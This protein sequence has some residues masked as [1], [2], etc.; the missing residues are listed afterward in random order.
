MD[1]LLEETFIFPA[2]FAQ[3]R[4]W[5]FHQFKPESPF[6]NV[7]IAIRL[8]GTLNLAALENSLKAIIGRHESLRTTFSMTE[9]EPI[10]IITS[11]LSLNIPIIDLQA[12]SDR[13]R[14]AEVLRLANEE[15]RG[16]FDLTTGPLMRVTLLKL[17]TQTHALLLTMHH[18]ISDGWSMNILVRE[19]TALYSAS[20][21]GEES[22]LP[23]LPIQYADYTMWQRQQLQGEK[24]QEQLSYWKHQLADAPPVLALPIDHPRP[25][26]Q[27]FRGASHTFRLPQ[28]L[29]ASLHALSQREGVTLFMTLLAAF[30]V[31]LAR[32]SGQQD[33]LVGSPSA[34]RRRPEIEGLIGF[35]V[36]TLVFR[37]DL[38]GNPGFRDLLQRVKEVALEAYMHQDIPFEKLIEEL[39]PERELSL[40]PL[41]QVMFTLQNAQQERLALAS[42]QLD[43]IPTESQTAKV[44]LEL[45]LWEFSGELVGDVR[46]NTDVF[47]AA[48]IA[49]MFEHFRI[50]L[51]GIVADAEQRI[52]ELPLLT[53]T[54]RQ[55]LLYEWNDTL[56]AYPRDSCIHHLF[57]AQARCTPD[58]IAIVFEDQQ[59]TYQELDQ[60]AN[61]LAHYLQLFGVGPEVLVGLCLDRSITM[62]IGLL[63]ILKAG[64]AY[65]PLDSAYPKERLAFILHDA[66]MLVLLTQQSL[67]E[68]LSEVKDTQVLCVDTAWEQITQQSRAY[69]ASAVGPRNLAYV[70]YTSGSTGTP[71]GVQIEHRGLCNISLAQ[72]QAFRVAARDRFLQFASLSFDVS[73]WEIV[74]TFTNGG[75]LILAPSASLLP[76]PQLL[77]LLRHQAITIVTLSPSVLTAMPVI[78]LPDLRTLIAAG[79]VCKADLVTRWGSEHRF[80]NAYGPTEITICA[81]VAH[82]SPGQQPVIGR[83]V[84]NAQMYVLDAFLQPVPIGVYGELYLGGTGSA[85]GYL[86]RAD[87][88]AERFLPHPFSSE[89]G[90]RLY[91][92]GDLAR[93][94]P[95]GNLEFLER[96]DHQVK[97]RGFRIELGEIEMVLA[98]HPDVREAVVIAREDKAEGRI[99][100][101]YVTAKANAH[102]TPAILRQVLEERLPDYM[103]PAFFVTL[104]TMPLNSSGKL[105]RRA[106]PAPELQHTALTSAFVPPRSV[107]E[108]ILSEIWSELLGI[109]PVG[110]RDDFFHLGGHSL[111]TLRLVTHIEARFGQR[112]PLSAI[113]QGRTIESLAQLLD[114]PDKSS[115]WSPLVTLQAGASRPPFFCV[116]PVEGSVT[117]YI[118][119][120][121]ALGPEQPFYALQA[122][123]L[124]GIQPVCTTIEEM[125]A[126]YIKAIQTVQAQGPYFL[127]GWSL[128]GTVAFEMARQLQHMGQQ[129]ALLALL[130]SWAPVSQ[131]KTENPDQFLLNFARNIGQGRGEVMSD[132]EESTFQLRGQDE[133]LRS[134]F[135]W[136]QR[137][138]VLS[139]EIHFSQVRQLFHV[140]RANREA[141]LS[142]QPEIYDG[143]IVLMRT[144]LET[145]SDTEDMTRGW[146]ELVTRGVE[147]HEFPGNHYTIVHNPHVVASLLRVCLER[148]YKECQCQTSHV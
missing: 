98:A 147:V 16:L 117:C 134:V 32:S 2:S 121:S 24:L 36:N 123:G 142:Y 49:R 62:I 93:Y 68:R 67:L 27:T 103:L 92:T 135:E 8:T 69:P 3:Q 28:A 127:G 1:T 140:F 113:F 86:R 12:L 5:F 104:A 139:P 60:R 51:Q 19:L 61:Q 79:E 138:S 26:L 120:S 118:K 56:A 99:L 73:I 10:Q 21:A 4:L 65:V 130:D 107:T 38:T 95:D 116:H 131:N 125:A 40:N 70:I 34:N 33:I 133:Q 46:Y 136:A 23:P 58:A 18:I 63:G 144:A 55:S 119:L 13:A 89:P 87:L 141:W 88:T 15:A 31:L 43:H 115:T 114:Q 101:A 22:P 17:T 111:L 25:V 7:P 47:E 128:G 102:L 90:A 71:K 81:S 35:F 9:E 78:P 108:Q 57:E 66:Q 48:T 44:E 64:G 53:H 77:D 80:Y 59:L 83:P 145:S 72:T 39:H 20:L 96:V 45:S 75:A 97:L 11:S 110:I 37:T 6:Y 76:G 42:L 143:Q 132:L 82:C 129:V 52:L 30:Q 112:L 100:V 29:T 14:E 85:R 91:K 54:E 105:D 41:F 109:E 122:S 124:D 74:M 137:V 106:L 146:S 148:A 50:L 94:L 126:T 84:C